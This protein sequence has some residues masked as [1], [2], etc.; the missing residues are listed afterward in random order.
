MRCPSC[1]HAETAVVDSRETQEGQSVRRR[2]VCEK[3]RFRF[4]TYE[5]MEVLDLV[6]AKRD[7]RE[8]PYSRQKL[9]VG[10]WKALE[11]RQMTAEKMTKLLSG[12]ER[13]IQLKTKVTRANGHPLRRIIESKAIGEMVIRALKK[14]DPVAYLRFASVYKSFD[15]VQ[16]FQHELSELKRN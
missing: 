6:V 9:E 3:C 16:A 13:E 7:G 5:E 12:I 10:L 15:N 1:Y 14:C 2:R 11:K 4:S 8:E